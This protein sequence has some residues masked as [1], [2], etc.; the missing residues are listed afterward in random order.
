VP[1]YLPY[2]LVIAA[3]TAA[4][5]VSE[6]RSESWGA[7]AMPWLKGAASLA[8]AGLLLSAAGDMFLVGRGTGVMFKA[9]LFSFL[10]GHVAYAASFFVA[11]VELSDVGMAIVPIGVA[12]TAVGLKL[13]PQ[14]PENLRRPV[15]AYIVVITIMVAA[16][17]GRWI[18]GA[19]EGLLVLGAATAF[20]VSDIF[21]AR[22]R[23]VRSQLINRTLGLPLY[24]GAQAAFAVSL[25][26]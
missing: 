18:G 26:P 2:C 20:W 14:A 10:G 24:Y 25:W 19:P 6:W 1:P 13:V 17:G 8:F 21:V 3:F 12:A 15:M 22:Q 11:G 5:V 9:G 23:F 16:A 4:L 7:R